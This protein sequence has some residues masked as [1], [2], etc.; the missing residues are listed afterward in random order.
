MPGTCAARRPGSGRYEAPHVPGEWTCG[1]SLRTG[2]GWRALTGAPRRR[3][4]RPHSS[5]TVP[6]GDDLLLPGNTPADAG[7]APLDLRRYSRIGCFHDRMTTSP[8][9]GMIAEGCADVMVTVSPCRS[10]SSGL[11]KAREDRG[12]RG[13]WP[14]RPRT[15]AP[16]HR[17]WVTPP[18]SL[19]K[20]ARGTAPPR[21]TRH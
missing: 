5:E 1:A 20:H 21:R 15:S 3:G 7:K 9:A 19:P 17:P 16:A 12:A 10:T 11:R 4:V 2:G 13:P 6:L 18:R 8:L 14:G